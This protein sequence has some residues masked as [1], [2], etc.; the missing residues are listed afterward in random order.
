M[1]EST[2]L[3]GCFLN[4]ADRFANPDAQ[5]YR[6]TSGLNEGEWNSISAQEML[7]RVAG[8]AHSLTKLGIRA[9]DRVAIFAPNCPEWHTVD[10]AIQGLSAVT[11]PVYFNESVERMAYILNDSG[12]RIVATVGESQAQ[13]INERRNELAGVEHVISARGPLDVPAGSLLYSDLITGGDAEIAEYRRTAAFATPDQLATIIYTSGTT[14]EPKGV[15]LTHAN[16]V[17]NATD[18]CRGFDTSPLDVELSLLPL[19]HIYGRVV[20]YSYIFRGVTVA[21]VELIESVAQ[22]LREVHPTAMAAVPRLYEKMYANIIERGRSE[23]GLKRRIFNW[24]IR[25]A[26]KSVPWRAH[27]QQASFALKW[28]WHIADALV[29]SKIR[30]GVG[31]KLRILSSGGAPIGAGLIEFF[32]SIGLPVYQGYGLTETSPVVTANNS[33]ANK[34][35]TVGRPIAGVEVRVAEDGEI[36]VK[37]KCVMQGYYKK[38]E[39]TRDAFTPDGWFRTGDIG[40]LDEDGYLIITDRKKELLKTAGGKFVAPAPIEN[41]LKTSPFIDNAIVFGDR[42]KFV[43][44]LIVPNFPHIEAEARKAG[45]EIATPGQALSDA[46]V[47]ELMK[48]EIERLTAKLAHYEQPKRFALIEKDFTYA[49]GELTYT[50]KLKRRVIEERYHDVIERIY[51]DVQEPRPARAT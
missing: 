46:W 24:A 6:S 37:G 36:L 42:R 22:A 14:G 38:P 32:W 8:L 23:T 20:D 30:D 7:R 44:V 40:N 43:S 19:A 17:S 47:L 25:K 12:A 48:S 49:G 31:G 5:M 45:R 10:F 11:V 29:Y 15:M 4:A 34:I 21:Y 16:L 28:Q 35:G 13:K 26:E 2:T 3:A 33:Q 51:A 27:G 1:N 41:L 50:L 39:D 18:S 9:G